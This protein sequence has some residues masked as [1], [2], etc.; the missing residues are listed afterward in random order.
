M[1]LSILDSLHPDKGHQSPHARESADSLKTRPNEK[2]AG[3]VWQMVH[4]GLFLRLGEG[5][6]Q[7]TTN[8]HGMVSMCARDGVRG[9]RHC[10]GEPVTARPHSV[11]SNRKHTPG[12][13]PLQN[14][15]ALVT[16]AGRGIGRAVAVTLGVH[17]AAVVVTARTETELNTTADLIRDAGAP[18]L[19][20]PGDLTAPGFIE[21]LFR[22]VK[23]RF[24]RVD[25]VVNNAGVAPF[26]PVQELPVEEFRRCLELNVTAVFACT[27]QAVRMMEAQGGE[28]K[29]I[30]LG[31]V[32][33]HWT[34]SGDAGAYNASKAALRALTESVARQLHGTGSRIAV[35]LVCPGVA[36]TPLTNPTGR[37]RPQW[38][39][40]DTVAAAVLH[41]VCAPPTVNV[42]DTIL[43]P[44]TQKP[45]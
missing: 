43:F 30:N 10:S 13:L 35:G 3:A 45:W 25:I 12:H 29:I 19:V 5:C 36:D 4:P 9:R 7:G 24:G 42:F 39:N 34:E 14:R 32:R 22:Q 40:P 8:L 31:S 20:V 41:A 38:L 27:Q 21:T 28:G 26:G 15:V 37:P 23:E 17:G 33:S 2:S 18:V 44:V 6:R 1:S 16:G 11:P